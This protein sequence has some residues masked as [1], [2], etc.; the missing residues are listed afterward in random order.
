[1][2][3][4]GSG[5]PSADDVLAAASVEFLASARQ[6]VSAFDRLAGALEVRPDA[7]ELLEPF[8]RE[9]H[10]LNGSAG[11]FGL[12]RAGRMAAAM[13][14]VVRRWIDSPALDRDRRAAVVTNFAA[15][16]RVQLAASAEA[17]RVG[18]RRLLII[19]VRD[20]IAV[21]ITAEAAARGFLVERVA[22]DE[23]DD[24]LADGAPFGVITRAP[25]PVREALAGAL[26]I[27]LVAGDGDGADDVRDADP[28]LR[29][30]ELADASHVL[31]AL[32][33]SAHAAR[34]AGGTVVVLDDD[35]VLRTI[36]GVAA[37]QVNLA[38][39]TTGDVASFRSALDTTPPAVLVLDVEIGEANGLDL[40]REV[41][42]TPALAAVPI[43][44]LSGRA[45][46]ATRQ[47]ARDAGANDFLVKPVSMA[48]LAA[49][50]AAWHARGA[51]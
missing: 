2:T 43:L 13:E 26:V 25:A 35:P 5:G 4:P 50:L 10:R 42:A 33:S 44:V 48:V 36:I 6:L 34:S 37:G 32:E 51:R 8:R 16:L 45:D 27:E 24:A 31:D 9:L 11:T 19:G 15:A 12:A 40:V 47:A 1:M 23:I 14:S 20:A 41:R 3:V 7:A 17:P 28:V 30:A 38:V 18:G 46:A 39:A 22:E 49:K 21:A 29:V